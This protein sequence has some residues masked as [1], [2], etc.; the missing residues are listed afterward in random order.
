MTIER[1]TDAQ[2]HYG[3]HLADP[4]YWGPYVRE[5]LDRHALPAVAIE[6]PFP[7]TF[8]TFLAGDLVVKL[9]GQAFDGQQS[10]EIEVAMHELLSTEREIRAPAVVASGELFAS[11]PSW[12][13]IV[14]ERVAGTAV[15]DVEVSR[16][17][18][19]QIAAQLG[20]MVSRLHQLTPP[21]PVRKRD[22]LP[23]L[24]RLAAKRAAGHGLPAHLVEQ[25]E[26]FLADAEPATTL[27]HGD[28]TADHVFVDQHGVTAIIDWGDA[29]VAD[30]AYELPAVFLD[31]LRGDA[32]HLDAFL[33]AANW[34]RELIARR[35]LQGILEFQFDAITGVAQRVDLAAAEALS[36]VARRLLVRPAT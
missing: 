19:A 10:S 22:L 17:F 18:G 32:A 33:E 8:P 13:Y 3:A 27:V 36:D 6:P 14:T 15:R 31:A 7:G 9:F 11:A 21:A 4:T 1:P 29:L 23:E 16:E 28:I 20:E 26:T 34:P 12:P 2:P 35:V 30:R 5:V 25:V 24:R